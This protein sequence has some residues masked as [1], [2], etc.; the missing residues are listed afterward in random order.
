MISYTKAITEIKKN[1]KQSHK[2]ECIN[3]SS[4]INRILAD[5]IFAN[6]YCYSVN[7]FGKCVLL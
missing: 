7:T 4:A 3:L 2:K 1:V 5:N 6:H